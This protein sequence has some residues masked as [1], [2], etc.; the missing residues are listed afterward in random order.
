MAVAAEQLEDAPRGRQISRAEYEAKRNAD[1][2]DLTAALGKAGNDNLPAVL[3]PYQQELVDTVA[4]SALTVYE[5]SRRTGVTWAAAAIAVLTSGAARGQGGM[6]SLY[7]GYNLDMAREFIDTCAMWARAFMPAAMAVEE[8]LFDDQ[9]GDGETRQIK[10]FRIAFASGFEIVALTSKPR[11]LRGRQGFVIIDEAAFH[12][13]LEELLK[14]AMALLMW[15]GKVLVISTHD[16][17]TNPFNELILEIRSGDRAGKVLHTDF[18]EALAQGLYERI[19]LVTGRDWSVEAEAQWREEIISFYGDDADEELFVIP[20]AGSGSWLSRALI[21]ARMSSDFEV[22]RLEREGKFAQMDQKLRRLDILDW[23]EDNLREP[24]KTFNPLLDSFFGMDFARSHDISSIVPGQVGRTLRRVVP[25][26]V[27]MR[28]IPFAQQR[29]VLFYMLD[30]LPRLRGGAL[31]A[32]GNGA[33]L[34]ENTA[35]EYGHDRIEQVKF[36]VEWYRVNMPPLKKAFE[37]D[38]ILLPS[39]KDVLDDLAL[40]KLIDGVARVPKKRAEGTDSQMRHGDTAIGTALFHFAT[41]NDF[42]EIDYQTAETL[43]DEGPGFRPRESDD[44]GIDFNRSGGLL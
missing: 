16:G 29:Q 43:L 30:R 37:D 2:G 9:D 14:A 7:I 33:E 36:S 10:S 11:S 13:A 34:A 22:I 32:G 42:E 4:Q 8:F 15:G 35:D 21:E 26:I 19:C 41:R 18:D 27:E 1:L 6:D 17:D 31:D 3:L 39:D 40:V 5:K 25:F 24:L 23:C 44:G 20:S 12:D 38:A 28:R